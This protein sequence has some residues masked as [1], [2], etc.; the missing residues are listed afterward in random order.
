MVTPG[1]GTGIELRVVHCGRSKRRDSIFLL[2]SILTRSGA[3]IIGQRD[4]KPVHSV[5]VDGDVASALCVKADTSRSGTGQNAVSQ[6]RQGSP[7]DKIHFRKAE[8]ASQSLAHKSSAGLREP[9]IVI[10]RVVKERGNDGG[11]L[12]QVIRRHPI[13]DI[14]I[15]MVGPG[16]VIERVLNEL[17]TG[18]ADGVE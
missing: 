9:G 3:V 10:G 2:R 4:A 16:I 12:F 7:G 17:K 18:Q 6:I 11:C 13:K 15:G 8:T 14:F 1:D 5:A